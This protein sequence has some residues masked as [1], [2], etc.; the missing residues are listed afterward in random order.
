MTTRR[1]VGSGM[2]HGVADVAAAS[3]PNAPRPPSSSLTTLWNA[4]A[5]AQPDPGPLHGL[6]RGERRDDPGLHVARPAAHHGLAVRR[7]RP[8]G[9]RVGIAPAAEVAGR[10]D[11]HMA[12]QHHRRGV[13]R[14]VRPRPDEPP[15]L[16]ARR[17]GA[18]ETV[19]HP[20]CV[21]IHP[22][23]VDVAPSGA[24]R[25]ATQALGVGLGGGPGDAGEP[26]EVDE[27]RDESVLVEGVEDAALDAGQR[28]G[29]G[30]TLAGAR[31]APVV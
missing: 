28:G 13:L 15:G 24:S 3:V 21:E 31:R 11:V 26:H 1:P 6:E 10:D 23:Q 29:H 16:R 9:E 19:A 17:L 2:T 8:G 27:V 14:A 12:L 5:P 20:Q 22:P 30:G 4:T 25:P 18:G 7:R